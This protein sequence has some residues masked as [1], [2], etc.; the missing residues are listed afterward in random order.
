MRR[1][2]SGLAWVALVGVWAAGLAWAG[3]AAPPKPATID[4]A[5]KGI[6]KYKYGESRAPLVAVSDF[7]RDT[8]GK[9]EERQKL[10]AGLIGLLSADA[11]PECKKFA[12]EQ[13]SIIGSAQAV[14]ELAKL[15]PVE[16][17]SHMAR[18]GL[19]RIPGP[20]ASKALRDALGQVKGKLLIGVIG[21]LG[22]RRDAEAAPAIAPF[23][24]DADAGVAAAAA[25]SLGKIGGDAGTKALA[26]AKGKAT[27]KVRLAV[28]DGYLRCA[29]H[30][31]AAEK[32]DL[33]AAIY[34]EMYAPAEAKQTRIAALRGIVVSKSEKAMPLVTEA[35][36]GAD[37]E[38]QA[39]A[40]SF[41]RE[42]KGEAE[43]KAF[44]ALLPKMPPKGQVLLLG[45]L[46]DRG[47]PAATPAIVAAV[48][49]E[50][51]SVRVAAIQA[52]ALIGDAS[53]IPLL[54]E[55][56]TTA[57]DPEKK[58]AS[59][60]LDRVRGQGIDA[61]LLK[62][63]DGAAPNVRGELLRTLAARRCLEAVPVFL[64]AAEDADATVR[65]EAIKALG[66]LGDEKTLPALVG[67][68]VKAPAG[69]ELDAAQKS[70]QAIASKVADPEKRVEPLLSALA[71][72]EM[73][74]KG[75]LLTVL[76]R[77]GGPKALEAVRAGVK[78]ANGAVQEASIRAL[79]L[80]PD[81]TAAP[82]LLDLAKSAPKP[83]LQILALQ[84]YVRLVGLQSPR[85]PADTLKMY[86][87]AMA[88]AT[89]PD[90]R[91]LVLSGLPEV[92][93]IA[94]LKMIEPCLDD[95]ALVAEAQAAAV[96]LAGYLKGT[97]NPAEREALRGD[98]MKVIQET[99]NKGL[100]DEAKKIHDQIKK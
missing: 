23:L 85:P 96:K 52:L 40:T 38:M 43:T 93:N 20:E 63:L 80:W 78:D 16:D 39:I 3:E 54:V 12:C 21:S 35:L 50:D 56:A 100:R 88:A 37:A 95:A 92:K 86:E 69:G 46:A 53:A 65:T 58:A 55:V 68:L 61:A 44:A 45:A 42:T 97:Q 11:T 14:P 59:D 64:K 49:G 19:E 48:K 6:T 89:R 18:T 31:V 7:V 33:A 70:I 25:N 62:A 79:T 67:F 47:D 87:S 30:L 98:L 90:E 73:P 75:S 28:A 57:K 74:A 24:Q 41:V 76:G 29:D 22:E 83:N 2:A 94:A 13:L 15:L 10:T 66:I 27:G 51:S 91:R 5:L 84:G 71:K 72:A 17:M 77:L 99:T 36:T 81:A 32:N 82:D 34:L 9:A 1:W 60:S 26:E 8:F 4:D